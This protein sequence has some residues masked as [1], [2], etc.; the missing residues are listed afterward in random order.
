MKSPHISYFTPTT[1]GMKSTFFFLTCLLSAH[2]GASAAVTETY[3]ES[4]PIVI[5][6]GDLSGIVRTIHVSTS[7]IASIES[8]VV[9]VEVSGGWAG[10]FYAYLWHD[11]VISVLVNRPGRS[12]L[13]PDGSPASG[14]DLTLTD[15]AAIDLHM[16]SGNLTGSFQPDGRSTHPLDTLDTDSRTSPLSAFHAAAPTGNWRL[17]IADVAAGEQGTLLNWSI[18][19]TG[20]EVVPE[21][22]SSLMV[23]LTAACALTRRNRPHSAQG[24]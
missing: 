23:V 14:M 2:L 10:D 11:G 24:R 8:L 9:N 15:I 4:T 12:V 3:T 1:P 18:S 17:F 22:G 7:T 5:P 19:M 16:A 6:D 21:P 13:N 20:L